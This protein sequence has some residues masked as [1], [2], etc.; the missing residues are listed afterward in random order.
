MDEALVNAAREIAATN[1]FEIARENYA[2]A[3]HDYLQKQISIAAE[4]LTK[5]Q[6]EELRKKGW[7]I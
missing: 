2:K 5:E 7:N 4:Y 3:N 6:K 1:I